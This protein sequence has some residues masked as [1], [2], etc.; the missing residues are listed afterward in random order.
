MSSLVSFLA[1]EGSR[2][3]GM[4]VLLLLSA[5]F[6]GSETAFFSLSRAAIRSFS[7]EKGLPAAFVTNLCRNP[8]ELL[9]TVLLGNLAVSVGYFSLAGVLAIQA[10]GTWGVVVSVL[11]LLLYIL[12]G[13]FLPKGFALVHPEPVCRAVAAPLWALGKAI[14]PVRR[15]LGA[16]VAAAAFLTRSPSARESL[17][18]VEELKDYVRLSGAAGGLADDEREMV[19]DV[20][21][22]GRIRLREVLVPRVD[23]VAV[24]IDDDRETL[25]AVAREKQVSKVVVIE[26]EPDRVRGWVSVKD[27]LYHEDRG[28]RDLLREIPA[29]P[30]TKTAE[31]LLREF[32]DTGAQMALVVD[33]Y[34]GTEGIVTPEDLVEEIVGEISDEYDPEAGRVQRIAKGTAI[35]PGELPIREWEE[36]S[37]LPLP[38]G[39][40]DTVGGFVLETLGRLPRPGDQAAVEGVRFTVLR[41][42]RSRILSLLAD[43]MEGRS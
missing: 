22:L 26:G 42:R 41:V 24:D 14:W 7:E 12:V 8:R 16:V 29:V 25:L 11:I 17:V 37:D 34:G 6:S 4:G 32:R 5:V 13:E 40:Y 28:I 35:V 36:R 20:I 38:R 27:F 33:E 18:T 31:S 39:K 15:G 9:V 3:A 2:L 21:E 30:E 43:G 23:M 19:R 10:G 1:E